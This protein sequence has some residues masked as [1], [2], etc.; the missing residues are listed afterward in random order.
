MDGAPRFDTEQD[1]TFSIASS[2]SLR[3]VVVSPNADT[4]GPM[5]E[6][7]KVQELVSYAH[8]L[9]CSPSSAALQSNVKTPARIAELVD[10]GRSEALLCSL[11]LHLSLQ[12]M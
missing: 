3:A 5:A 2:L 4:L 11:K 9:A 1:T 6:P 7:Q 8:S 10:Q 12:C